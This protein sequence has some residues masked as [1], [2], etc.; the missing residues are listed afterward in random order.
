MR[1]GWIAGLA[2]VLSLLGCGDNVEIPKRAP[3]NWQGIQIEVET[4]PVIP[5]VGMNEFLVIATR[6]VKLRQPAHDLIISLRMND[7]DPWKQ[8]IQDGYVGVYRR[9]MPVEDPARE[10]VQ[11][12]VE[13][14]ESQAIL[15]FPVALPTT[16]ARTA[17][18]D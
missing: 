10:S 9:A 8:A 7:T 12:R 5:T 15:K 4:R 11:V 18:S 14:R 3:Q 2:I 13:A 16:V 1:R 17:S 6:T